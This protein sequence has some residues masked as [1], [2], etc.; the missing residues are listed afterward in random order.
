[1]H[2]FFRRGLL[3][4]GIP[5]G[6]AILDPHV[7]A[8]GPAQP[9]ERIEERRDAGLTLTVGLRVKRHQH[10]D[11]PWLLRSPPRGQLAAEPTVTLMKSRRPSPSSRLRTTPTASMIAAG[12]CGR[13]N[14]V[15]GSGCTVATLNYQC[16]LWVKSGHRSM[17]A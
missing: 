9:L 10:A 5:S 12:I 16:P 14:G 2:Q 11:S 8:I 17:S 6:P 15:Q 4:F 13:R 7:P 1:M 3:P